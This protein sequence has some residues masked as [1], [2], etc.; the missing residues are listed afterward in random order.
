MAY[1]EPV[2]TDQNPNLT[3][4]YATVVP[5][6]VPTTQTVV[7]QTRIPETCNTLIVAILGTIFCFFPTR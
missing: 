2:Y 5:V 1:V 7:V 4:Q 3:P 6:P